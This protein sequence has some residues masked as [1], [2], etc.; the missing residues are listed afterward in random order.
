MAQKPNFKHASWDTT[1]WSLWGLLYTGAASDTALKNAISQT[2]GEARA[3][4]RK[5]GAQVDP[6]KSK[7][8]EWHDELATYARTITYGEADN[9][10][11]CLRVLLTEIREQVETDRLL[12]ESGKKPAVKHKK[13]EPEPVQSRSRSSGQET[14]DDDL[15]EDT[16]WAERYQNTVVGHSRATAKKPPEVVKSKRPY[17][18]PT[19]EEQWKGEQRTMANQC[20]NGIRFG[21]HDV[22][23]ESVIRHLGLAQR[24]ATVKQN[25]E[26]PANTHVRIMTSSHGEQFWTLGLTHRERRDKGAF[27]VYR[28]IGATNTFVH[29]S[30]ERHPRDPGA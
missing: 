9:V 17:V 25:R 6:M 16:A 28:R 10:L 13:T 15:S 27:S 3:A 24:D 18:A 5:L 20:D 7:V 12:V 21:M 14:S 1:I 26:G 23:Q 29:V 19:P 22:T 11:Q 4:L 30:G 2:Y 8:Q